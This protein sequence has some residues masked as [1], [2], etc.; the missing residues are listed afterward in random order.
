MKNL[1]FFGSAFNILPE[2]ICVINQVGDIQFVNQSWIDFEINNS[3]S[4]PTDWLNINYFNV[5]QN[6]IS[7]SDDEISHL[8]S[9][10]KS[11]ANGELIN[12]TFEY[13]CHSP[14]TQRWFLLNCF[15]FKYKQNTYTLLQHVNITQKKKAEIDCNLDELTGVGN[16]RAFNEFFENEWLRC[17]RSGLPISV[18]MLD[19]DD[20]KT[21]NDTYGHV[22]GDACLK[23]I[24]NELQK[25]VNRPTDMFCRFG[26]EEFIYI[27]GNTTSKQA[28]DICHKVHQVLKD[29]HIKHEALKKSSYVTVSIGL[30]CTYPQSLTNRNNV[31]E[32]ADKY[33]YNA[34]TQGKNTTRYHVCQSDTCSPETCRYLFDKI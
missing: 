29:L 5:C 12:Y 15:P 6:S 17:A 14:D 23:V 11:V 34:K 9:A 18:I 26:G 19:I 32:L 4:S 24:S 25:L 20:F 21:F 31:I 27:L 2:H 3:S 33:L 7:H 22:E 10:I 28:V 13:P 1:D 8:L 30:A 16:R